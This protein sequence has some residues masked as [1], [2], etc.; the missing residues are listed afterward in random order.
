MFENICK[1]ES[2]PISV[3]Y[4][5]STS[6]IVHFYHSC[7]PFLCWKSVFYGIICCCRAQEKKNGESADYCCCCCFAFYKKGI[8]PPFPSSFLPKQS[9]VS[10]Y[11]FVLLFFFSTRFDVIFTT[12]FLCFIVPHFFLF[13]YFQFI[14]FLI[15][16]FHLLTLLFYIFPI[17]F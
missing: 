8:F 2:I 11:C 5:L 6:F 15:A 12:N 13:L 3:L 17:F 16:I 10:F 1:V 4:P 7:S 14:L 9:F